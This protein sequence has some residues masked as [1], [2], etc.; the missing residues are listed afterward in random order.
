MGKMI[1]LITDQFAQDFILEDFLQ[2][3]EGNYNNN[4][5]PIFET[6][7]I[8]NLPHDQRET[9]PKIFS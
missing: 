8:F 5:E 9:A 7:D 6:V 2:D 4:F 3:V 1:R